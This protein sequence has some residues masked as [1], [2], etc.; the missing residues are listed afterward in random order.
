MKATLALSVKKSTYRLFVV[1][2]DLFRLFKYFSEFCE[3]VH[4]IDRPNYQIIIE[5]W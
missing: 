3:V 5:K 4:S 1:D 2:A